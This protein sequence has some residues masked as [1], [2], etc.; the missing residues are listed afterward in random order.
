[1]KRLAKN[2]RSS[3]FVLTASVTKK[4]KFYNIGPRPTILTVERGTFYETTMPETVESMWGPVPLEK[5]PERTENLCN[6]VSHKLVTTHYPN[7]DS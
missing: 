3:W 2:K 6:A 7:L 1:L 5:L 4:K